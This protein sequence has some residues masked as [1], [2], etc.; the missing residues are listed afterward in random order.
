MST[1]SGRTGRSI[2]AGPWSVVRWWVASY[3][4]WWAFVGS[5]S[6]WAAVWGAGLAAVATAAA[7]VGRR[8]GV[9]D[10]PA[11]WPVLRDAASAVRQVVVDFL[12]TVRLLAVAVAR[13][14]RGPHGRFVVRDTDAAGNH[15]VALRGWKVLLATYSPNA[16]VADIDDE[17][18][19]ALV[20]DLVVRR[21]SEEPV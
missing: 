6:V 20:H 5:W 12:V 17:T 7:V 10:L 3:A 14:D 16:W 1:A 21:D 4:L 2:P 13:G 15:A 18:G 8:K 19:R 11:P 9:G